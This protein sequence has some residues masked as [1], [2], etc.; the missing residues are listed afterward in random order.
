MN[1]LAVLGVVL[2]VRDNEGEQRDHLARARRHLKHAVAAGIQSP[3]LHGQYGTR[4][5]I[6]PKCVP[7]YVSG[8]TYS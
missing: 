7:A 3:W 8:R 1:Q 6:S 4:R 2:L 5:L